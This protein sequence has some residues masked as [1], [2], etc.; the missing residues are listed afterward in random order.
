MSPWTL[1]LAPL[2]FLLLLFSSAKPFIQNCSTEPQ[3]FFRQEQKTA[4]FFAKI[5]QE[6]SLG[7]SPI[8]EN[9][10]NFSTYLSQ[11]YILGLEGGE[12]NHMIGS[13]L[14]RP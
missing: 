11:F 3:D 2:H 7:L 9:F 5:S 14:S 12:K 4:T 10:A 6:Q 8:C 1:E 13:G